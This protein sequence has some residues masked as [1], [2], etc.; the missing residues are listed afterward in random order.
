MN[1]DG[2]RKK[3]CVSAVFLL[4]LITVIMFSKNLFAENDSIEKEGK[5]AGSDKRLALHEHRSKPLIVLEGREK[6]NCPQPRPTL[7]APEPYISMKNPLQPTKRDLLA[8]QTLF[9]VDA[10]PTPCQ[11]C[12]GVTGNGLGITP[13]PQTTPRNFTCFETMKD[14]TDGQLFWIIQNGSKDTKMPAYKNLEEDQIWQLILY[15]RHFI[16]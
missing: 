13:T 2:V 10:K 15:L 7:S 1:C 16:E 11:A 3:L 4:C 14:I 12:H 5:S 6:A 8:G 9:L